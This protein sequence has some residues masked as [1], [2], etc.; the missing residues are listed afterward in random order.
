[1]SEQS[2][3]DRQFSDGDCFGCG[4]KNAR[5]LQIKSFRR[6]DGAVLAHWSPRPEHTNGGGFVCGGILST[7]LDC[8]C[9]AAAAHALSA[10][11]VTKEFSIEFLRP[12]PIGPLELLARVV[13]L[14]S[15]SVEL[16]AVASASGQVCV[17]FRGVF[18]VPRGAE[19]A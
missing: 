18:V 12:T 4:P 10:G 15:R 14:R 16:E 2:I 19:A 7:I 9:A 1:M 17:R 11:A 6:A 3:Q 8:H 13:E 5:G